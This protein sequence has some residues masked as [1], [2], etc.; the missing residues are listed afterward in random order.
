MEILLAICFPAEKITVFPVMWIPTINLATILRIKTMRMCCGW[1]RYGVWQSSPMACRGWGLR[2]NR[3][4][5]SSAFLGRIRFEQ[6]GIDMRK[7]VL[8]VDPHPA[9]EAGIKYF[10]SRMPEAQSSQFH[11]IGRVDNF[12]MM[13]EQMTYV[14]LDVLITEVRID[15]RDAL[16]PIEQL[17]ESNRDLSVIVY[18]ALSDTTHIARATALGCYDFIPKTKSCEQLMDVVCAAI[19]GQP[20]SPSSLINTTRTRIHSR[21]YLDK[22]NGADIPL[23]N[24]EFQVL[25]HVALGLSNRE[26]GKSLSISVETVKEHVQNVLKKLDVN[27][28]TQ[29]AVLAVRNGWS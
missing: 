21:K 5:S 7:K 13:K 6:I 9:I 24:R 8:L 19:S 23:T 20:A 17:M 16:R 12:E 4:A 18:S 29:A 28:R 27:D 1:R 22:V 14:D 15:G 2:K 3:Q 11:F 26:I 10:I 25:G